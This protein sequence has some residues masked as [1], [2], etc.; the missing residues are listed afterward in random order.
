MGYQH[1]KYETPNKF[2]NDVFVKFG[3]NK[4]DSKIISDVLLLSDLY[5]IQSHGMQRMVRYHKGIEKGLI[6]VNAKWDIVFET[7]VS[8]VIDANFGIKSW[9]LCYGKS[10]TKSKRIWHRCCYC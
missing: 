1:F 3:F 7:P 6:D 5:G 4:E 2:C 8:C 9:P 10:Y